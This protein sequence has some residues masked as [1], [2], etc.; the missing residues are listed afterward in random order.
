MLIKTKK[1]THQNA[2][3]KTEKHAQGNTG[4]MPFSIFFFNISRMQ[5]E[6]NKPNQINDPPPPPHETRNAE[7]TANMSKMSNKH[8]KEEPIR[9]SQRTPKGSCKPDEKEEKKNTRREYSSKSN[10]RA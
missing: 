9:P 2:E 1:P 5:Q 7:I 8:A 10:E 6:I 4:S 3:N